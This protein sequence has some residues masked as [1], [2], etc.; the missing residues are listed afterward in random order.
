MLIDSEEIKRVLKKVRVAREYLAEAWPPEDA[1]ILSVMD[2]HAAV[3]KIYD[4]EIGM[5]KVS[6][7]AE[8][9]RGMVE[10]NEG[11]PSQVWVRASQTPEFLRFVTVKEICHLMI[12]EKDDW[13]SDG[14]ETIKGLLREW[15]LT[16][17]N[18]TG[19]ENPSDPL[20]SEMLAEIAAIEMMYPR[21]FRAADVAKVANG[22]TTVEKIAL[23][24]DLPPY[25]IEQALRHHQVL[26]DCWEGIEAEL[27]TK[28]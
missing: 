5:T 27:E 3:Q 26:E 9:L 1:C 13:S 15:A 16:G 20:M 11:K 19:H 18:G 25:A 4:I 21:E 23:Q 22:E 24:H 2:F 10:R 6:F 17:E 12:D 8:H 28:G 7:Q 14:I